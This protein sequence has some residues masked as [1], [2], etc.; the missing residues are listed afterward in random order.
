VENHIQ[1]CCKCRRHYGF[2]NFIG[3]VFM[4]CITAGFWV[5]WIFVR[6][7][8]KVKIVTIIELVFIFSIFVI[9]IIMLSLLDKNGD[10]NESES[11]SED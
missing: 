9:V 6:R 11:N 10:A 2:F 8:A 1:Y 3:D 5:I 7:C 4:T